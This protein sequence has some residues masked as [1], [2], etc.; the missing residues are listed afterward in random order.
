MPRSVQAARDFA[1]APPAVRGARLRRWPCATAA[2]NC[3]D[4]S[5][6]AVVP[7]WPG[8]RSSHRASALELGGDGGE[9]P[10]VSNESM[11]LGDG[12]R[13][14]VSRTQ[15]GAMEQARTR[16]G[17]VASGGVSHATRV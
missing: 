16:G 13:P 2:A 7:P 10:V 3:D 9:G 12:L 15:G 4:G 17:P 8:H 14:L 11:R 5:S 1:W 6:W